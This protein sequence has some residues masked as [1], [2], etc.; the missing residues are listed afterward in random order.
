[1]TDRKLTDKISQVFDN[2]EDP[3]AEHGWQELRKKYPESDKK[4]VLL[5]WGAAAAALVV[6]CGLWFIVPEAN[7]GDQKIVDK[8]SQAEITKGQVSAE[9]N[10]SEKAQADITN[11]PVSPSEN[12]EKAAIISRPKS[13]QFYTEAKRIT[14]QPQERESHGAVAPAQSSGKSAPI[15]ISDSIAPQILT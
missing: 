10:G 1:M 13:S 6:L 12:S 5:W 2:F 15:A 14:K 8:K 9:N 4:P 3:S 11:N 7:L